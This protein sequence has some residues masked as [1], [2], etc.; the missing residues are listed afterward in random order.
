MFT[1]RELPPVELAERVWPVEV[2]SI[3][4]GDEQPYLEL[5]GEVAAGRTSELRALVAGTIVEVG[6]GYREGALVATGDLLVQID[7]FEYRNDVAEQKALLKETRASL[8]IKQRDLDRTRELRE[9]SNISEQA[10][11]DSQLA[12]EQQLALLEQRRIGLARAERALADTR[13]IAPYLGVVSD[14]SVDLGKRLSVNDKVAD[15]IDTERLEVRFTLT[16]AQFG[17]I[18]ESTADIAGRQVEVNW[19]VGDKTLS[20]AAEV[21]RVGAQIDSSTGGVALYASI[22]PDAKTLLRPGAFVWIR[23]PDKLYSDVYRVPDSALYGK[24]NVY[25]VVDERLEARTIEIAGYAQDDI[26][27]RSA[28]LSAGDKVVVTQI[29]EGGVGIKVEIRE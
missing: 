25:V 1:R 16:N 4:R 19:Q 29:R 26:L 18:V 8:K 11:D 12:V 2:V 20:Y 24:D 14:V 27:F 21:E 10:L 17:R 15:L 13:L 7:P 28:E 23:M 6:P 9:E 5:F 22:T 3:E